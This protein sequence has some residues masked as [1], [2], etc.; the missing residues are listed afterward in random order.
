MAVREKKRVQVQ[1]DKDLANDTKA[2]LSEL[3]LNPTTAIN[4]FYK[5]IVADGALPFK[6]ALSEAEKANLHL[7]EATQNLPVTKFKDAKEVADWLNIN[8][9]LETAKETDL[10]DLLN[11]SL[12]D[13]DSEK[14]KVYDAL[15]TYFLDK[16]QDKVIKRK[17]FVR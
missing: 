15:Y 5:R 9:F 10:K 3:G 7:L 2:V 4:M 11:K 12:H 8:D 16:R 13:P 1:I 6:P 14:R 17:A